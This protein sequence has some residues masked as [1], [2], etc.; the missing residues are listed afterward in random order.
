[1]ASR[2]RHT[3]STPKLPLETLEVD[4][5]KLI[6][7]VKAL[8][9]GDST[10]KPGI[11]D[12]F[13]LSPLE[14]PIFTSPFPIIPSTGVSQTLNFGS[15]PVEFFP[16]DLGL[17]GEILITPLSLEVVPWFRPITSTD[18]P[19]P[20]FTTPPPIVATADE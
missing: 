6:I 14:A 13:L 12:D 4:P 2:G 11:F 19:T 17:E 18:F 16:P 5:K 9:E 7:K 10:V 3:Q 20:G 1:M 8:Q 15:V